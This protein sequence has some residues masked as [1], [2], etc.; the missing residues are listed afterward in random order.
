MKK[1][2]AIKR[3]T[4]HILGRTVEIHKSPYDMSFNFGM[5]VDLLYNR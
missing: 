4:E 5:D 1:E 2:R 3:F